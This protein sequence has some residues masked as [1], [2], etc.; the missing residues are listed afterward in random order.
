MVPGR[1]RRRRLA[2]EPNLVHGLTR[3]MRI[4]LTG[5]TGF[6]GRALVRRLLQQGH[7]LTAWVRNPQVSRPQL[8]A[9]VNLADAA[10]GPAAL[11]TAVAGAEAIVNLAGEPIAGGRW[12]KERR[13]R[14]A[15]SRVGLTNQLVDAV[16]AAARRPAVLISASA[17]GYYGDRGDDVIDET[18]GPGTGFLSE[19]CVAWEAAAVR[20]EPLGLRVVRPRLG[21]VLGPGGGFLGRLLPLVRKGLGASLGSGRQFLPWVHIDDLIDV[22]EQALI[23]PRHDG[24]VDVIAPQAVRMKELMQSLARAVDR[25]LLPSVPAVL[26]KIALGDSAELVLGSQ[27]LAGLRLRQWGHNPQFATI[28]AAIANAIAQR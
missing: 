3:H 2:L 24:S 17:V 5:A 26:L 14:I 13:R 25:R 28:D 18:S 16:A 12:T 7:Q 20:A 8:P 21:V 10:G 9:Q 6:L 23:D 1:V 4:F 19:I 22:F 15:D 11:V 27:H